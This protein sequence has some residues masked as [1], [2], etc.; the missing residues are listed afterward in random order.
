MRHDE[1]LQSSLSSLAVSNNSH[2]DLARKRAILKQYAY[3]SD[4]EEAAAE[5]T[6]QA[7]NENVQRVIDEDRRR[8]ERIQSEHQQ[9]IERDKKALAQQR[10]KQLEDKERRRNGRR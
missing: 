9:R 5:E 4:N 3:I 2:E 10:Q 1:S 8:K 6:G 7:P